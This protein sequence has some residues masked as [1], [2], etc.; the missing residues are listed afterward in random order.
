MRYML[1]VLML[2]GCHHSLHGEWTGGCEGD[3]SEGAWWADITVDLKRMQVGEVDGEEGDF[4]VYSGPGTATTEA[5]EAIRLAG[6]QFAVCHDRECTLVD[7]RAVRRNHVRGWLP[8]Q[9]PNPTWNLF[10]EGWVQDN[11]MTVQCGLSAGASGGS[12]TGTLE[13][14]L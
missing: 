9:L 6:P 7:G 14:Q 3:G 4:A 11:T 8:D 12:G 1:A 13:R 5:A 10:V 2:S